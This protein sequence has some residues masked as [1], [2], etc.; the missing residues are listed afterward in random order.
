MKNLFKNLNM[1]KI[2]S[3]LFFV[4]VSVLC[5]SQN[6]ELNIEKANTTLNERGEVYFKFKID[7][8]QQINILT[9]II[10][11][12]NVKENLVF[13]Y[14]N[15]KQFQV[16]LGFNI[17]FETLTP[18]SLLNQIS[19]EKNEKSGENWDFYPTYEEYVNL[20]NFYAND[21]SSHCKL[22]KIGES[23]EGRDILVMKISDNVD[24]K[25][26]EPEFFYTSTMHG[27]ETTGFVLMLRLI[28]YLAMEYQNNETVT[29]LVDNLEIWINPLSNPDGTYF[30]GNNT[31][32]GATRF[33]SNYVD[34]NRNYPDPEDGQHPDGNS[35]Q[36][37]NQ[38]MINFMKQ[39]N[40][41][42]S[43]NLHTGTEVINYPWDTWQQFHADDDWYYNISR[44]YAD[45][46]HANIPAGLYTGY[47]S[48]FNNG[49]TN[50]FQ[51]YSISGGRQDY[52]NYFLNSREV[53]MELSLIKSP[54]ENDLPFFWDANYRSLL[55]YMEQ[56]IY[57]IRGIVVDSISKEAIKP[58]I[59]IFSHDFDNS[60]VFGSAENGNYHRLIAEGTYDLSINADN[61]YP[62]FFTDVQVFNRQATILDAELVPWP[63]HSDLSEYENI[64]VKCFPNP[65]QNISKIY[66]SSPISRSFKIEILDIFGRKMM[67]I[68]NKKYSEGN[69]TIDLNFR[70]LTEGVYFVKIISED[71]VIEKTLVKL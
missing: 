15:K 3:L 18:P 62:K 13:A 41:V 22:E 56:A 29:N 23:V 57:G 36:K 32:A 59:E 53:T 37:E 44:E 51:W 14:A 68:L 7:N 34:L 55:N 8:R 31:V 60:F 49:I 9:R 43:A 65:V 16:F 38:V 10:S 26:A 28:S 48:D 50:G 30:A 67:E 42:L 63:A 20:M 5:F 66:I 1:R 39:H 71:L 17:D 19:T 24:E 27:D 40:F 25:E 21:F 64:R 69:N 70:N 33:N 6:R 58:K 61:H 46:V 45:T 2:V 11:I 54:T 52:M 47:L 35:L 12:D 4:G